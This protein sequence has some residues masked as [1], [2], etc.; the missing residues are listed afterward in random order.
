MT[1]KRKERNLG[2]VFQPF[3]RKKPWAGPGLY[4]IWIEPPG[5]QKEEKNK[6]MSHTLG[7]KCAL[8][9]T[10]DSYNGFVGIVEPSAHTWLN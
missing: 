7:I 2:S 5:G 1:L 6:H 10:E 9:Q 4:G 3:N 8:H